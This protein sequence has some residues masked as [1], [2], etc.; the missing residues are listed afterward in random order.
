MSSRLTAVSIRNYRSPV[1]GNKQR[2]GV[3]TRLRRRSAVPCKRCGYFFALVR[4]SMAGRAEQPQGWPVPHR[5]FHL[6][7][8]CHPS[9]ER[10][11]VVKNH[12]RSYTM[13]NIAQGAHALAF[14]NTSFS[15]VDRNGQ[16][17]LRAGE[18]A[19][20]LGYTD[21]SAINRIYARHSDE[22]TE[23]M[24]GSVKLT[25][26]NGDKQETRIFSLRGAHLL[27][28]FARTAK[29]AEFRHWVLD[30]IDREAQQTTAAAPAL[31]A[32]KIDAATHS[33]INRHAWAL[34]Q[35]TFERY[36]R[37]LTQDVER[38]YLRGEIEDWQPAE[39]R[40]EFIEQLEASAGICRS[41]ADNIQRKAQELAAMGGM[42]YA[43]IASK[44][45][46]KKED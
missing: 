38:D 26:P 20:A 11:L 13:A 14:Q 17:W 28:M 37:E 8:V 46:P 44:F 41:F 23:R 9:V 7:S 10:G 3:E 31:P 21:A 39:Y 29:A 22:F 30:I 25:D 5:Y 34:A 16:H 43:A 4:P 32:P 36:R 24:T 15:V 42:D 2:P 45:W 18:I 27:A 1:A 19:A 33:R 6:R 35:S 40:A 12:L